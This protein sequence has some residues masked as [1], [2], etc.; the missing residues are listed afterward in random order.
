MY[1]KYIL[2]YSHFNQNNNLVSSS[3]AAFAPKTN[4]RTLDF[5]LINETSK[6]KLPEQL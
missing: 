6:W 5:C 1:G 3:V 4:F 2:I